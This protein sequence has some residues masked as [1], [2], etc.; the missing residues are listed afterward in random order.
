MTLKKNGLRNFLIP[1]LDQLGDKTL[2]NSL[3][4]NLIK[5]LLHLQK[6]L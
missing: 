3:T 5:N 6:E 2:K 4:V 1:T